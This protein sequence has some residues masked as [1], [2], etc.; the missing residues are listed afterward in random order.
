[1]TEYRDLT[2][3]CAFYLNQGMLREQQRVWRAYPPELKTHFHA[4]VTDDLSPHAP[5]RDVFEA[6]GI[7]SQRLFLALEHR[8]FDWLFCRNLG[9]SVAATEWLLLTDIDHV[10][11][12]D[13][14]RAL[15]TKKL[16]AANVYRFGR[17]DAHHPYP[18]APGSLTDYKHHPNSWLLT[19][20]MFD[21][22][23][24]YDERFS[25]WYGSDSE[26]RERVFAATA[27][28]GGRVEMREAWPLVRYPREVIP[29]ASTTTY[30]RKT[31]DDG[32]MVPKIKA[33]RAQIR[34]A[35]GR[36]CW[37][38]LRLTIPSRLEA[39]Y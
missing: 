37:K 7:A 25:G 20:K 2:F 30:Q 35:D 3:I 15:L 17:V 39:G 13:T 24:G 22:I 16:H 31:A 32:V 23:G 10:V 1:M 8:R 6:T 18:W 29:D 12:A 27:D 4:I 28:A 11:P 9:A 38:P 5:A 14:L 21:R 19:K 33:E 34:D 36:E 26:F